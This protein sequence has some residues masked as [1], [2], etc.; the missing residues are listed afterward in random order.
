M[1]CVFQNIDPIPPLRP[2]CV[3]PRLC[4]GGRTHSPGGEG[5]WGSIFWKTQDT[6]LYSTYIE[7]S[8]LLTNG[9]GS[10][11]AQP[12]HSARYLTII[13][14]RYMQCCGSMTFWCGSGSGSGSADPSLWLMYPDPDMDP[15]I[16]IIDLQ[17]ANKKFFL[18]FIFLHI[19]FWR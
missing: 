10:P 2:V 12:N 16:F 4:C 8:L 1:S 13:N 6:A 17:D 19:T 9:S 3:Y 7:S 18:I 15:S 14:Y 11:T 5:G